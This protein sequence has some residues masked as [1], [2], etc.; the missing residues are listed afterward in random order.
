MKK[1][2]LLLLLT[3]TPFTWAADV[4]DIDLR[5][6][7]RMA[8]KQNPDWLIQQ[9]RVKAALMRWRQARSGLNPQLSSQLMG[10]RQSRDMRSSGISFPASSPQLGPFNSMDARLTMEMDILSPKIW[11]RLNS[12]KEFHELSRHQQELFQQDL[13]LLIAEMY[14][15]AKRLYQHWQTR[16]YEENYALKNW[17]MMEVKYRQGL[18]SE[19]EYKQALA[20]HDY[21]RFETA[22]AFA[23]YEEARLDLLDAL[24]LDMK[25]QLRFR[26]DNIPSLN[27]RPEQSFLLRVAQADLAAAKAQVALAKASLAPRLTGFADVG[28]A[29][30]GPR[31]QS[32]IFTVGLKVVLPIWLGGQT[33]AEIEE[34]KALVQE[35]ELNV[36]KT[37][38]R[39]QSDDLRLKAKLKEAKALLS[40]RHSEKVAMDKEYYLAQEKWHKGLI[41]EVSL[42]E[43][44]SQQAK[45]LDNWSEAKRI[46]QV[47]QLS[48][49]YREGQLDEAILSEQHEHQVKLESLEQDGGKNE[50]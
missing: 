3:Y 1:T 46:Y 31:D 44:R 36:L 50:K 41:D 40:W 28:V 20:K 18:L 8:L 34:A 48:I 49:L 7:C 32:N 45:A 23:L 9:E 12:A 2:I 27:L 16:L 42:L 21:V 38:R 11:Q 39:Y 35:K 26:P 14:L 19:L 17:T 22:Q 6:A 24:N 25:T 47:V 4:M 15:M 37:T 33:Q 30:Q 43:M 10:S 29:G 13:L 5:Q